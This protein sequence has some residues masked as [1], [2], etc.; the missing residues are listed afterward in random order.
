[1]DL[2]VAN[3]VVMFPPYGKTEDGF[4][5]QFGINH[6]GHFA[7]VGR[8]LPLLGSTR[9]ARLIIVSSLAHRGGKLDFADLNRESR[10]FNAQQA[11][12]DSKLANLLFAYELT[13]RLN[14]AGQTLGVTAAHPGWTRT[15]LQR[16]AGIF[17]ALNPIFSQVAEVGA[18]PSLRAAFDPAAKSGDY[19]GPSGA[20]EMRGPPVKVGSNARSHDRA[21]A[22]TLWPAGR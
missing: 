11:Y 18:L 16:H 7:L 19:F 2:L 22:Q 17:R 13:R 6:L 9:G 15:E 20:L 5:L 14:D 4:E 10:K 1:L 8:L 12:C 3:A 21:L